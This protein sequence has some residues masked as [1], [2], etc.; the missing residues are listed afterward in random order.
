MIEVKGHNDLRRDEKTHALVNVNDSA[1]QNYLN[2]RK[3]EKSYEERI[4]RLSNEVQALKNII[5]NLIK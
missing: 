5:N 4:D 3:K 2:K 1:Y